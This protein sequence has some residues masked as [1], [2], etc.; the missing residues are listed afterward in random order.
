MARQGL[1]KAKLKSLETNAGRFVN[2][3]HWKAHLLILGINSERHQ[4][5]ATE[6][7]LVGSLFSHGFPVSMR[8]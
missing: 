8:E 4:K 3:D 2:D 1:P 7:A 6:G 5:I